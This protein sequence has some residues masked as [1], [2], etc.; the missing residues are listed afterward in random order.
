MDDDF[1]GWID[2]EE[3][4]E[5]WAEKE[6]NQKFLTA[7]GTGDTAFLEQELTSGR[8][9]NLPIAGKSPLWYARCRKACIKL[10]C[11]YGA[12]PL[13]SGLWQ[14]CRKFFRDDLLEIMTPF[15]D[16]SFPGPVSGHGELF[17][18]DVEERILLLAQK[19]LDRRCVLFNETGNG[20]FME[21]NRHILSE[22]RLKKRFV[23]V[24]HIHTLSGLA[25]YAAARLLYSGI[26][27]G[28]DIAIGSVR[29]TPATELQSLCVEITPP[30]G[31]N[32]HLHWFAAKQSFY[33]QEAGRK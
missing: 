21:Y 31:T 3:I 11:E 29:E 15:F 12:D 2:T 27:A 13:C 32:P 25:M 19:E 6:C 7:C 18:G 4:P 17:S 33:N 20:N 30:P 10:L 9:P 24:P 1:I 14:H 5:K 8:D 23:T 28:I 16:D 26:P 22:K